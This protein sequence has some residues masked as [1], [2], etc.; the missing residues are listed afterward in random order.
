[1]HVFLSPHMDD[2]TLSCGGLIAHLNA[3]GEPVMVVN[4][5]SGYPPDPLP[6]S[7]LIRELHARWNAEDSPIDQRREEERQANS[8]LGVRSLLFMDIPDCIYRTHNGIALYVNGDADI[9]GTVHPHDP[10]PA[11]LSIITLPPNARIYAPLAI[12]GH[13]D[14]ILVRDW[15]MR[16]VEPER[17]MLYEDYPY[18]ENN[19]WRE[20]ALAVFDLKPHV[21]QVTSREFDYK[22]DAIT[23]YA[24]QI[25]T[26]WHS[27][28]QMRQRLHA[29]M[30]SV[31]QGALAERYWMPAIYESN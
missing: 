2:T 23:C 14:H 25:S 7:P 26:F 5:M 24:S 18:A 10:A 31:G 16:Y 3:Q 22:C 12:R 21:V 17:L 13:V 19:T 27:T 28:E 15:A 20:A 6:E 8:C 4:L 9:F 1:M 11:Q 29:Y 30:T